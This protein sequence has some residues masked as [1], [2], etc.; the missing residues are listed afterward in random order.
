MKIQNK[1]WATLLEEEFEKSYYKEMWSKLEKAYQQEV[2]YPPKTQVFSAFEMTDYNQVK[3]VILGQDPYHGARQAH[4][5]CFSV[6]PDVKIPPSLMNIYKELAS[7]IGVPIPTHGYLV[8]W[9]KQGILMMNTICTVKAAQPSSHKHLGWERFTDRV[10]ELL[11]ERDQG[12]VFVLWG[13]H[14]IK[15]EALIT[16]P[17][18][19]ILKSPHP[20]PFS[21]RKG[22]LGSKPFSN[23]NNHLIKMGYDA[24]DWSIQPYS[25]QIEFDM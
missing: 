15:K 17:K 4:G 10:I 9:A 6:M 2:I 21:A 25:Q 12:M 24:V 8:D 11:N 16:N 20:S 23:I 22:F 3:V 7:D 18:H 14:A 13:N 1:Q 5:L 19:R